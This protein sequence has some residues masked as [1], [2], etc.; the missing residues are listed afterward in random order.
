MPAL[1][2]ALI[3]YL[4]VSLEPIIVSYNDFT[5]GV[6]THLL[7]DFVKTGNIVWISKRY[8]DLWYL[9]NGI[10]ALPSALLDRLLHIIKRPVNPSPSQHQWLNKYGGR[11][12]FS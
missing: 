6:A 7:G 10:S 12:H 8:E 5:F 1:L 9:V 4:E 3:L 2:Q 11:I